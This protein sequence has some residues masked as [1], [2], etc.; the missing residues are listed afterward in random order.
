MHAAWHRESAFNRTKSDNKKQVGNCWR[1][2]LS[3]TGTFEPSPTGNNEDSASFITTCSSTPAVTIQASFS[4]SC[5]Q[6]EENAISLS[7]QPLTLARDAWPLSAPYFQS[8]SVGGA[9]TTTYIRRRSTRFQP[10]YVR[11]QWQACSHLQPKSTYTDHPRTLCFST[12]A[13]CLPRTR[14]EA[15]SHAPILLCL[16][17]TRL[18]FLSRVRLFPWGIDLPWRGKSMRR[19]LP[20]SL[21]PR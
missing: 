8:V 7:S 9:V 11:G 14:L 10:V 13:G 5:V 2:R 4:R 20:E 21:A 16:P 18:V 17:P 19:F 6:K 12:Q 15:S 3:S 1:R